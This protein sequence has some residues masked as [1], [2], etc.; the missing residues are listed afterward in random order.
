MLNIGHKFRVNNGEN[1]DIL[2]FVESDYGLNQDEWIALAM[3]VQIVLPLATPLTYQLTATEVDTLLGQNNVWHDAN[4]DTAVEYRAD[5]K[6]YIEKKITAA[7][8]AAL[9]S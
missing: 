9:N 7:I 2:Y 3:D 5:T 6:L 4:G 8:A 1:W